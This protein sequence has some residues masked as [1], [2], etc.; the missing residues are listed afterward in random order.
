MLSSLSMF[1]SHKDGEISMESYQNMLGTA[2]PFNIFTK[3][4]NWQ[5]EK[6]KN[7]SKR[8]SVGSGALKSCYTILVLAVI[9][10]L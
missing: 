1:S 4:T 3:E 6:P 10:K 9:V 7:R 5:I 8:M 2:L